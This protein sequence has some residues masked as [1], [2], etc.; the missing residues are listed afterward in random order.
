MQGHPFVVLNVPPRPVTHVNHPTP[1]VSHPTPNVNHFVTHVFRPAIP[2]TGMPESFSA[3]TLLVL[4]GL[5]GS[6]QGLGKILAHLHR[7]TGMGIFALNPPGIGLTPPLH[8]TRTPGLAHHRRLCAGASKHDDFHT[9]SL[10]RQADLV[11]E[12]ALR[13]HQRDGYA[14]ILLGHSH[15]STLAQAAQAR[16]PERFCAQILLSPIWQAPSRRPGLT[17]RAV[18]VATKFYCRLLR[19]HRLPAAFIDRAGRGWFSNLCLAKC[20]WNGWRSV[21]RGSR[22]KQLHPT[23][24]ESLAAA[25]WEATTR[26]VSQFSPRIPTAIIAGDRDVLAPSQGLL[27]LAKRFASSHQAL[28]FTFILAAGHLLHHENWREATRAIKQ[29]AQTLCGI[30]KASTGKHKSI[31]TGR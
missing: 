24:C 11:A 27:R 20:G 23:D 31:P 9:G 18:C 26:D 3:H 10:D 12:V 4:P 19:A 2:P 13:L 22:E 15:G 30:S 28:H 16:H 7:E 14:P 6:D 5:R 8:T 29:G 21:A 17:A 1:R 25:Q